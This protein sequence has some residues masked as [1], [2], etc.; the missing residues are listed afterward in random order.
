MTS[1]DMPDLRLIQWDRAHRII[2]SRYPPISLFEDIAD[3]TKWDLVARG[4]S[5]T[6]S[7]YSES[8]GSLS[9]V[10]VKRRVAGPGASYVMA[11]FVHASPLRPGRFHDG[12]FGAFYAADSFETAIAEVAHHHAQFCRASKQEPGWTGQFRALVGRVDRQFHDLDRPGFEECL[13]PDDYGPSQALARRL[14]G[15]GSDGVHYPSVRDPGGFCIAAFWP[16]V[17]SVPVQAG[18]YAFEFDGD[19]ITHIRDEATDDVYRLKAG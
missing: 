19:R 13:S 12:S 15:S 1:S 3:P 16:D 2:S 5:R 14:R 17:V 10:P 8:I 7:Q 18:H 4:E 6:N 9:M 11:P